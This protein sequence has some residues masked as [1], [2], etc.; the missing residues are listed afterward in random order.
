MR[1]LLTY[2]GILLLF[3]TA[4]AQEYFPKNDGVKSRYD[5]YTL[6]QNAIIHN[7]N[8]K[9]FKGDLLVFKGKIVKIAKQIAVE[10]NYISINLDGKHL[11]PSFIDLTSE[12]GIKKP[13]KEQAKKGN[14]YDATRTGHYWNDHIRPETNAS[15]FFEYEEEE[16]KKLLQ[17]GFGVVNTHYPDGIMRGTSSLVS[18]VKNQG[19]IQ[20]IIKKKAS[21]VLSFDKSILSNQMYPTSTMGAMALIRQTYL[22]ANWYKNNISDYQDLALEALI[23]QENLPQIFITDNGL[24]ELRAIKIGEEFGKKYLVKGNGFEF[25]NLSTLRKMGNTIIAPLDFPKPY[26]ISHPHV[27]EKISLKKLKRWDQ[28]PA[29]LMLLY[30]NE[31]PFTITTHGLDDLSSFK[32]NLLLAIKYG[33]P[34]EVALASLT[35]LPAKLLRQNNKIGSLHTE[36]L[37]NFFITDTPYF[38]ENSNVLAHVVQGKLHNLN[39]LETL[40]IAGKYSVNHKDFPLS[41]VYGPEKKQPTK[42]LWNEE[43]IDFKHK[44]LGKD[45]TLVF[46]IP[47]SNEMGMYR[48]LIEAPREKKRLNIWLNTPNGKQRKLTAV[49]DENFKKKQAK[50]EQEDLEKP[51]FS[52]I[53]FPNM[54]YGFKTLPET[55]KFL[56]KNA[57]LWTN[58][59][60][61]IIE[62]YDVLIKDGL[63][64]KIGRDL[65][66][67]NAIIID[68]TGKHL[69]S[70]IIDEHSHIAASAVNEAG[71]NSTAEVQMEDVIDPTDIN[72]YRNLAGGVTTIQ[73]LHGSANPIGGQSA[74]LKLRWGHQPDELIFKQAPKFIKFALGENVKQS[75]WGNGYRFPQTRMGVEQV[76]IDY[77]NQALAYEQEKNNN[78]TYRKDIE[79]ETL[80]EIVRS[81][82]FISCHSYV[83]SEI[84]MLMKVAEQFGFTVNTF[85]HILEGYKVADK[86]KKHGAGA[87]TFS[88]W[89][90]YKYEVNDAIPY[91]AGI[92]HNQGV[93]TAINSDDAEMSRRLNQE[94]AKTIKYGGLSEEDAWKTVTLNPAKLLHI[95]KYV[96]SIKEGK[97]ADLVLWSDHPL[98]IYAKA[99]KTFVDGKLYFDLE[100]DKLLRAQNNTL[101]N[102]LIQKTLDASQSG[103]ETQD[104]VEDEKIL[105]HCDTLEE[106]I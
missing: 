30:K 47:E 33:L 104:V 15:H 54:A 96:G 72:I 68:A 39:A 74:I 36:K 25:E 49:R 40:N 62:N 3:T 102:K 75:N 48:L 70:G 95:D 106:R 80:L 50:N 61:G 83:Q 89:W 60:L 35:S 55:K 32:S 2:F 52:P 84:N 51:N 66:S 76:Y 41:L 31:I 13:T 14:G 78:S 44:Q 94:A 12:F 16:A 5:A 82:R 18:L 97:H 27:A 20:S 28:A 59:E 92:L 9:P 100:K 56:I 64:H 34:Q 105:M 38:N 23:K 21:T 58:E 77:F 88:D 24:D 19:A 67:R 99:E 1:N 103:S 71:H 87:S 4:K 46:E 65:S 29:N 57:T 42:L 85:T 69:T 63:I 86:M 73:L 93:V 81:K 45:Q 53:S 90:A 11:Y 26:T 37:A 6:Y 17:I 79:L 43:E 91:N 10:D 101:K 7:P 98:S 8:E 22:D